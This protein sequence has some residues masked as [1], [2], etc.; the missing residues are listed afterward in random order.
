MF[1]WEIKNFLKQRNYYIGGDDLAFI[2]DIKQHPQIDHIKF[3]PYD[4]SYEMWDKERKLF[5]FYSND[6]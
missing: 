2:T 5:S 3:N 4:N 6:I 1:S